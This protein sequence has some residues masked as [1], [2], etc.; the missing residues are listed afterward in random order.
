MDKYI[1]SG[2]NIAIKAFCKPISTDLPQISWMRLWYPSIKFDYEITLK[3][4]MK[5]VLL[6]WRVKQIPLLTSFSKSFIFLV[7]L[8]LKEKLLKNDFWEFSFLVLCFQTSGFKFI[9]YSY[10]LLNLKWLWPSFSSNFI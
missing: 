2:K 9:T 7:P 8:L 4:F 10:I 3:G 6:D 5:L 1:P